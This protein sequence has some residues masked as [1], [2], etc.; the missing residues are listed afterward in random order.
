MYS[1][2]RCN[3]S[4]HH[5]LTCKTCCCKVL[6]TEPK[7]S[8]VLEF[9]T[10]EPLPLVER[11]SFTT[12]LPSAWRYMKINSDT[13]KVIMLQKRNLI[14]CISLMS[15]KA[16]TIRTPLVEKKGLEKVQREKSDKSKC[17]EM[18]ATKLEKDPEDEKQ[19]ED[20]GE[21]L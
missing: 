5:A 11:C 13:S 8:A 14:L 18:R 20:K 6:P 15:V 7:Q 10:T 16:W 2:K 19:Q 1:T 4:E 21:M 17:E 12:A 3:L 9:G